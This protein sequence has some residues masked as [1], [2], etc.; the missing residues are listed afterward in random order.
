MHISSH[1]I[2]QVKRAV[3]MCTVHCPSWCTL[4]NV[5]PTEPGQCNLGCIG[6]EM[7]ETFAQIQLQSGGLRPTGRRWGSC[8]QCHSRQSKPMQ[9]DNAVGFCT[10]C[11]CTVDHISTIN[12]L[13]FALLMTQLHKGAIDE[14]WHCNVWQYIRKAHA[15]REAIFHVC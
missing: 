8:R 15:Q 11:I 10:A 12:A 13:N 5:Q 14:T 2:V 4:Y 7:R 9:C 1:W 6:D 3:V